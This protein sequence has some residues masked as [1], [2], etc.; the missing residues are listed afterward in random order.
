MKIRV[1]NLLFLCLD[2]RKARHCS[3]ADDLRRCGLLESRANVNGSLPASINVYY[4]YIHIYINEG[5]HVIYTI[6]PTKVNI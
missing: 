4:I 5:E 3:N 6:A 1:F 2:P